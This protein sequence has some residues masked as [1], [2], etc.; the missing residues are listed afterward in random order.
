MAGSKNV[1]RMVS[2]S[3]KAR[4]AMT[5]LAEL[6]TRLKWTRVPSM[7]ELL[8]RKAS[9]LSLPFAPRTPH[10]AQQRI[11]GGL[12]WSIGYNGNGEA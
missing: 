3:A 4:D 8:V 5:P 6:A 2:D 10:V 11:P 9:T 7:L 12:R 1:T